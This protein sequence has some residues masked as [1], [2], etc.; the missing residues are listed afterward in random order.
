MVFT[1][2]LI[3]ASVLRIVRSSHPSIAIVERGFFGHGSGVNVSRITGGFS[4]APES[5]KAVAATTSAA[6]TTAIAGTPLAR[7]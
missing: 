6:Q 2:A 5:A 7:M 3:A 4:D 1:R